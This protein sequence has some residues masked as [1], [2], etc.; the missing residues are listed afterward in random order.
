MQK[1]DK[2]PDFTLRDSNGDEWTLSDHEGEVIILLFYP[3]D[4]TPV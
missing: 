2:A 4:D 3:G 1:G